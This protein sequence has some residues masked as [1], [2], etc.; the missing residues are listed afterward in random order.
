VSDTLAS[1]PPA[2]ARD[3]EA[4]SGRAPAPAGVAPHALPNTAPP[5]NLPP[6][7]HPYDPSVP[8]SGGQIHEP[9]AAPPDTFGQRFQTR[10]APWRTDNSE[11]LPVW[12]RA[13]ESWDGDTLTLTSGNLPTIQLVG[14]Q[15]GRKCISVACPSTGTAVVIAANQGICDQQFNTG[16]GGY[17]LKPGDS[18]TITTEAPV[19]AGI[20]NGNTT[21][22]V[23][24][25]V[26]FNPPG[27]GLGS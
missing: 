2:E 26:E 21:A 7:V 14:R 5:S 16:I 3:G 27:G 11:A 1:G 19:W 18:V 8:Y 25:V 4:Q 23:Q 15:K 22:T 10:P 20:L 12:E 17:I 9:G 13:S 24:Y 6:G